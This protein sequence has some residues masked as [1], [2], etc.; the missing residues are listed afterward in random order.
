[1]APQHLNLSKK[2]SREGPRSRGDR[3]WKGR[4]GREIKGRVLAPQLGRKLC[5]V[6]MTEFTVDTNGD[7][8][9]NYDDD[10]DKNTLGAK[11]NKK[12]LIIIKRTEYQ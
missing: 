5:F 1:M 9:H 11:T 6:V 4:K 2:V 7:G 8:M 3:R 12:I 10:D